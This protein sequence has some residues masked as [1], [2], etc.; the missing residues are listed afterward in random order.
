M[1]DDYLV[2]KQAVLDY[3]IWILN[4]GYI[5]FSQKGQPMILVKKWKFYLC[6]FLDKRTLKYCLMIVEVENKPS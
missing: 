1:L 3:K 5:G 6:I 2:K 4:S